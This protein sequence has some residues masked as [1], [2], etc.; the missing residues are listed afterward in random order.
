MGKARFQFY[1]TFENIIDLLPVDDQLKFYKSLVR[2]GLFGEEAKLKGKDKV[3]FQPIKEALDNQF[4][5]KITNRENGKK[6][7]APKGTR[8]NPNGRLGKLTE[9]NRKLTE[10]NQKQPKTT[11]FQP[12][13]TETN[14]KQPKTRSESESES[15]SEKEFEVVSEVKGNDIP[16]DRHLTASSEVKLSE[17]KLSKDKVVVSEGTR[18]SRDTDTT[19]ALCSLGYSF[20]GN[21]L[22]GISESLRQRELDADFIKFVSL[23]LSRKR[24]KRRE[25]GRLPQDERN[26]I[27]F[28]ALTEWGDLERLYKDRGAEGLDSLG[29]LDADRVPDGVE[30]D[31]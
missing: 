5:R 20:G 26:A 1:E 11:D 24:F 8:N 15:E 14:Q 28:K 3:I 16:N 7:G 9:T 4:T 18:A 21:A 25:Y 12:K 27:F 30:I 13:L 10:T 2:Y 6:G 22:A 23:A 17:F 29:E 31:F 19:T